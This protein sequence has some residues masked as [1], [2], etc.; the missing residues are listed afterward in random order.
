MIFLEHSPKAREHSR[1]A[2]V[3]IWREAKGWRTRLIA[4]RKPPIEL[5][6]LTEDDARAYVRGVVALLGA[7]IVEGRP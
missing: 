6:H 7:S 5:G 4:A 3:H 1:G 2:R